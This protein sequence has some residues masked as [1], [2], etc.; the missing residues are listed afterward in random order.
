MSKVQ[1][2]N[3]VVYVK[4]IESDSFFYKIILFSINYSYS[5]VFNEPQFK[6][7]I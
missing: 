4:G 3:M 6:N 1:I 7:V 5:N 2:I